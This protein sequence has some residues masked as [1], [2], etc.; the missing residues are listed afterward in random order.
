M[1]LQQLPDGGWLAKCYT[2]FMTEHEGSLIPAGESA[3]AWEALYDADGQLVEPVT[4][5]AA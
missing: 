4:D 3:L 5:R 1:V 2:Q